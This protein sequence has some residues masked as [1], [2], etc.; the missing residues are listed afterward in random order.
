MVPRGRALKAVR[1]SRPT[2]EP[3]RLDLGTESQQSLVAVPGDVPS[4]LH[5][6]VRESRLGVCDQHCVMVWRAWI[7]AT[8]RTARGTAAGI[9]LIANESRVGKRQEVRWQIVCHFA[10]VVGLI[11]RQSGD[12]VL[13]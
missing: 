11:K 6:A 8:W 10:L 5:E 9:S 13:P 2:P 7:E 4:V 3:L 1:P 12:F